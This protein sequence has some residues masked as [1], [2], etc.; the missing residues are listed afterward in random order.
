ALIIVDVQRDFCQG[1]AL[2]VPNG[3]E[4]VPVL[5]EYIEKFKSAGAAVIATRDWHP[6]NHVSFRSRGGPWPEH[7]VQNTAGAEFHP[8][9]NLPSDVIVVSKGTEP[10]KE[11]Y[12][13]FEGT[14]LESKLRELGV[15]KIFVGGLATDY[16]VKHTVLDGLKRGFEVYLLEDAVRG[17]D[18]QKGD[19]EKAIEEMVKKGAKRLRLE[20]L[21]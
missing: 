13:G 16:C 17:V 3:D 2:A 6:R 7:C 1:G 15:S 12:S 20:D 5:N 19:S 4:V 11:A 14:D 18:V 21:S 9:L 10:D 8:R